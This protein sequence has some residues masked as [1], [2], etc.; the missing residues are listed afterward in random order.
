MYHI[1][2]SDSQTILEDRPGCF[3]L[4]GMFFFVIGGIFVFGVLGLF[5]NWE[6]VSIWVRLFTLALGVV[7]MGAGLYMIDRSPRSRA[8][9]D[10]SARRLTLL[11]TGLSS[12]EQSQYDFSEI[13]QYMIEQGEDSGGDPIYRPALQL[14]DGSRKPISLL[15]N[16]NREDVEQ[17]VRQFVDIK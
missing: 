10:L 13:D 11:R 5:N 2:T 3:W 8:I 1:N 9:W 7:G 15:W 12:K 16:H 14:I 4:F 6:E 17:A